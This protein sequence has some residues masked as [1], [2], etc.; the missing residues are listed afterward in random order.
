MLIWIMVLEPTFK[1][2]LITEF[3][4][5][6]PTEKSG[7]IV[8]GNNTL[9]MVRSRAL[10]ISAKAPVPLAVNRENTFPSLASVLY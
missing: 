5:I 3:T 2:V 1:T 8:L 7:S 4:V 6:V 10:I 9:P